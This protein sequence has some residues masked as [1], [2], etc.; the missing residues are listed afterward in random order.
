MGAGGDCSLA[1][2]VAPLGALWKNLRMPFSGFNCTSIS[3]SEGT[4][5]REEREDKSE[6]SSSA[7]LGD[8][9]GRVS[10][11]WVEEG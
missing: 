2:A 6:E 3:S 5:D 1:G 10:G 8:S 9:S 11:E 7:I 4:G